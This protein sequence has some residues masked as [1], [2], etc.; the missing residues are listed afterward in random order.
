M[1]FPRS[2]HPRIVFVS[3]QC[4]IN[5][6][7]WDFAIW[8]AIDMRHL[9]HGESLAVCVSIKYVQFPLISVNLE[10]LPLGKL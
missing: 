9:K 10:F 4:R 8:D 6:D 3:D 1:K 5:I 2:K 7:Q